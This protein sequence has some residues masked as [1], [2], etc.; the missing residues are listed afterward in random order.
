[1]VDETPTFAVVSYASGIDKKKNGA[2]SRPGGK[3]P[4]SANLL[5]RSR[6]SARA[7]G[8]KGGGLF[9][10]RRRGVGNIG[11]EGRDPKAYTNKQE[12]QK[13]TI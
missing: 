12:T 9:Q 7:E 1:V 6:N 5:R 3:N 10:G 8:G 13:E 11:R 4:R 2:V